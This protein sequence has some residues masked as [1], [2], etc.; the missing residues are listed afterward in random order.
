MISIFPLRYFV[1]F[2]YENE[3]LRLK[4]FHI[5][6]ALEKCMWSE[7]S[8]VVIMELPTKLSRP[9]A[10]LVSL[11][12]KGWFV[13]YFLHILESIL[14][15]FSFPGWGK[16]FHLDFQIYWNHAAYNIS[17]TFLIF[18]LKTFVVMHCG[19]LNKISP[20]RYP[21]PNPQKL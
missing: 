3:I 16:P 2:H 8:V 18:N 7:Y 13:V 14:D 11:K 4:I 12:E 20:K 21:C 5:C 9:G 15:I 1:K 6:Y 10:F 19:R 17:L